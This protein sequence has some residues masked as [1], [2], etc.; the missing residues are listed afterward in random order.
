MLV[1]GAAT[2]RHLLLLLLGQGAACVARLLTSLTPS[3]RLQTTRYD[4]MLPPPRARRA[5]GRH[6]PGIAS[7]LCGSPGA[8][9]A[10][11][12]VSVMALGS[13]ARL[14]PTPGMRKTSPA[15]ECHA[16]HEDARNRH[17]DLAHMRTP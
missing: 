15:E 8:P 11:R 7:G 1:S 4:G 2:A 9:G 12:H 6:T 10:E 17:V 5:R 3:S 16:A 14:G 13:R